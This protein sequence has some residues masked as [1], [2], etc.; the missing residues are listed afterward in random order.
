MNRTAVSNSEM[1]KRSVVKR[2][3]V[4]IL[5]LAA[6]A[7][8]VAVIF[9]LVSYATGGALLVVTAIVL[10][11]MV[12]ATWLLCAHVGGHAWFVPLPAA[13]AAAGWVL[14]AATSG[15]AAAWWLVAICALASGAGL[16]VASSALRQ[17]P[18][19]PG[20]PTVTPGEAGVAITALDPTGVV[21]IN[22]E[23]WT[24]TSLSGP[25]QAGAPV[26][27]VRRD[28]LRIEVWSEV[29]EVLSPDHLQ[30]GGSPPQPLQ[31]D[32]LDASRS[33]QSEESSS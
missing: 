12:V 33:Q 23:T 14:A 10:G 25:L 11:V 18:M 4:G 9:S 30:S 22:S 6:L 20:E 16:T 27:V 2:L 1:V 28:G 7:F 5:S 17:R 29:G 19:P 3:V 26:H 21:R 31:P 24:A 15:A 13:A 32:Q 8:V